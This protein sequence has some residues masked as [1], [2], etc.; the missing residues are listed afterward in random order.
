MADVPWHH[1]RVPSECRRRQSTARPLVGAGADRGGAAPPAI[2]CGGA[3]QRRR[4]L[5]VSARCACP[6]GRSRSL[7]VVLILMFAAAVSLGLCR[8]PHRL[9]RLVR[10]GGLVPEMLV[11]CTSPDIA[12]VRHRAED[13]R[14]C[15]NQCPS[16]VCFF[17]GWSSGPPHAASRSRAERA[18][19]RWRDRRSG[20]YAEDAKALEAQRVAITLV[21][22]A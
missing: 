8:H 9:H 19:Q 12:R 1:P 21:F 2:G 14:R 18:M 20:G 10:S 4:T 22:G 13:L 15:A 16:R 3:R 5:S 11:D 17:N 7:P 6:G